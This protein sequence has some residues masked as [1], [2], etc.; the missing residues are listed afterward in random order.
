MSFR[1]GH[2]GSQAGDE[3]DWLAQAQSYRIVTGRDQEEPHNMSSADLA[4]QHNDHHE[5]DHNGGS[6]RGIGYSTK[7]PTSD[8]IVRLNCDRPHRVFAASSLLRI[9]STCRT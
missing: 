1:P 4:S 7:L 6:R 3:P 9:C 2:E 8:W 5:A